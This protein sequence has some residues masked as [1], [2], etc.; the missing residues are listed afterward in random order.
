M[1]NKDTLTRE[2]L[3]MV[4]PALDRYA[5]D[6]VRQNLWRRADLSPRDRSIVT[7]SALVTR[8]QTMELPAYVN[9]A[10]ESGVS[11]AEISEIVTHLAFYAGWGN[12]MAAVPS[13]QDAFARRGIGADQLPRSL[14]NSCPSTRLPRRNVPPASRRMSARSPRG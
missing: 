10:L 14:R 1:S 4:A 13:V 8:N 2:G 9:L 6:S 12:A 3:R 11:P 5:Q 7:L